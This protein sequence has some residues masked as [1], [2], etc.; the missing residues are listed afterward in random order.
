MPTI[1]EDVI[2]KIQQSKWYHRMDLGNGIVTP[3]V[4]EPGTDMTEIFEKAQFRGKTV[5]DLG[6]WDGYWSFLAEKKGASLVV[7]A[8]VRADTLENFLLARQILNSNVLPL[9]TVNVLDME[10]NLD[11][12]GIPPL[13]DVIIFY[14]VLHHLRDPMQSLAKIRGKIRSGGHLLLHSVVSSDDTIPSMRLE[15]MD[16]ERF[17]HDRT[18]WWTPTAQCLRDMVRS[19]FFE[20]VSERSV[21]KGG[22]GSMSLLVK[23]VKSTGNNN[24]DEFLIPR[25]QRFG[26]RHDVF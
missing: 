3:G 11:I 19:S 21:F 10:S 6:C 18:H 2:H 4:F 20:I 14:G 23:P 1:T 15:I 17:D 25:L 24:L 13:F 7:A 8:D 9:F 16:P 26:F 22:V 12:E 5:L